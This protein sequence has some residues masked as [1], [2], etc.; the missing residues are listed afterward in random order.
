VR[1][2]DWRRY[3]APA[4]FLL[5]ATIAVLL[6]RAGLDSGNTSSTHAVQVPTAPIKHVAT[7]TTK[8]KATTTGKTT[9]SATGAK[10]W[11]VKAGDTFGVIS[12]RSGVPVGEL[13]R[14]NP[15]VSSTSLF[16]GEKIRLR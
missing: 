12:T 11:T 10:F 8:K 7:T 3:A 9:T 16:I 13:Q 1:H 2:D 5:A 15:K 4:A 6:I 14:L